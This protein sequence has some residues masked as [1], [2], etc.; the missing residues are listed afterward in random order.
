MTHANWRGGLLLCLL[1]LVSPYAA[2]AGHTT[3]ARAT[4]SDWGG[5][6][7]QQ[8]RTARHAPDGTFVFGGSLVEPYTRVFLNWQIFPRLEA[9]FRYTDDP[10]LDRGADL[11]FLL[12]EE[13]T[14]LP[15]VSF[16][17]QDVLGTGLFDG[18]YLVASKR[19]FDL[20]FSFG[21]VWGYGNGRKGHFKNPFTLLSSRFSRREN[22]GGRTGGNIRFGDFFAGP[23]VSFFGGVEYFTPIEGLSLKLEYDPNDY[24]DDPSQLADASDFPING[25]IVYRPFD[26][27]ELSIG[28]ERG[29]RVMARAVLRANFQEQGVDKHNVDAPPPVLTREKRAR[30]FSPATITAEVSKEEPQLIVDPDPADFSAQLFATVANYGLGIRHVQLTSHEISL[31]LNGSYNIEDRSQGDTLLRSIAEVT[32]PTIERI[33]L[34][35]D[36]SNGAQSHFQTTRT[37][38]HEAQLSEALFG[39]LKAIGLQVQGIDLGKSRIEIM[40]DDEGNFPESD[41]LAAAR[42]VAEFP[43]LAGYWIVITGRRNGGHP[44]QLTLNPRNGRHEFSRNNDTILTTTRQTFRPQISN[45][46]LATLAEVVFKE[47]SKYGLQIEA[48]D[49]NGQTATI[50]ITPTRFPGAGRNIGRAARI[51]ANVAPDAV[52]VISVVTLQHG[53]EV[54]KVSILRRDVE[55]AVEARGSTEELWVNAGF[56]RGGDGV[57]ERAVR[58]DRYPD[59]NWRLS[60][61]WQQSVGDPDAPYTFQLSARLSGSVEFLPGLKLRGQLERRIVDTF[62]QLQRGP[63]PNLEPVRSNIARYLRNSEL[64]LVRLQGDYIFSPAKNIYARLSAGYFE[65]MFG[66]VGGEVLYRRQNARWA[67]GLDVNHVRQREFEQQFG[68]QDYEVTTGHLGLYYQFPFLDLEGSIHVGRYLAGDRGATMRLARRF[69]SGIIV[70]GFFTRTNV[71]AEDF[72]EGSFDK[73]FFMSI[74]LDLILPR[75]SRQ[76]WNVGFR[77]LTVDGGQMVEVGPRLYDVTADG[78]FNSIA[79]SW[80]RFLD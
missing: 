24:T 75:P 5:I 74:P 67:I 60:P 23:Y 11:K 6:G 51:V 58:N 12:L 35:I 18:E 44:I 66:G 25:A 48:F 49:I 27:T 16:G 80:P 9:T 55:N 13:D 2:Q 54:S 36:G 22:F 8:T 38:V 17:A 33:Q 46:E 71:S 76:R 37:E 42:A 79:R 61:G 57:G 53:T 62:D 50:H 7:L 78:Q 21:L 56:D 4:T 15:A 32:P 72:G 28:F 47:A 77:P 19:Y 30:I 14:F 69:K 26:L 43:S 31:H 10:V 65:R 52:E 73:G 59:F 63:R 45:K 39:K 41:Y 64:P 29:N 1:F 20:D 70:G 34:R 40:V 3:K 68:F